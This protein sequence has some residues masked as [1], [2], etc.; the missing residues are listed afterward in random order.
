MAT[1]MFE[2]VYNLRGRNLSIYYGNS[3]ITESLTITSLEQASFQHDYMTISFEG[4]CE[5]LNV[6]GIPDMQFISTHA[7][8]CVIKTEESDIPVHISEYRV[9]MNE[10]NYMSSSYAG[11]VT[12]G[13]SYPPGE[14]ITVR[15]VFYA[16]DFENLQYRKVEVKEID[17][18][19]YSRFDILDL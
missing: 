10:P 18:F 6:A 15:G 4:V 8:P 17:D 11:N 16:H 14:T 9:E 12:I 2:A 7:V 3:L 19:I 13:S 1:N 5:D